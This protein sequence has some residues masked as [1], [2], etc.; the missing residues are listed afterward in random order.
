MSK[1]I[2]DLGEHEYA[3]LITLMDE[4]R[5][6]LKFGKLGESLFDQLHM[7]NIPTYSSKKSTDEELTTTDLGEFHSTEQ[8]ENDV[9]SMFMGGE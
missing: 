8:F 1:V 3:L 4:A 2:L 9:S 6:P 7:G 5:V